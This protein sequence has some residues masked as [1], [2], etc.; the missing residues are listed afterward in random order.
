LRPPESFANL[1]AVSLHIVRHAKAVART[2]H[3]GAD[4]DRPLDERGDAQAATLAEKALFDD[5]G[6]II[7][8]P[9]ARCVQ[10]VRPLADRLGIDVEI[11]CK[12]Y[13]GHDPSVV[14]DLAVQHDHG[15]GD[16]VV[17]SHGDIIPEALHL[18]VLRGGELVG[19]RMVEKAS[20][21][22][23]VFDGERPYQATHHA[24]PC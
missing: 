19:P 10:T 24:A 2:Q 6:R 5:V 17:C 8:S 20:T 9:A 23:V 13:E 12:L 1:L 21:W 18:I 4:P 15:T 11:D 3:D 7:A 16:L 14:L 22:T